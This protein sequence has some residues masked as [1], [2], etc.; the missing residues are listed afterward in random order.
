[1]SKLSDFTKEELK[2][3][4]EHRESLE[5]EIPK[6]IRFSDEKLQSIIDYVLNATV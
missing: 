3:E 1:M 2:K 4:L 6:Q 5:K